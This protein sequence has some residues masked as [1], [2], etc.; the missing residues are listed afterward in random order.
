MAFIKLASTSDIKTGKM[1]RYSHAGERI[2]ICHVD[3]GFYAV[4]DNCSHEDFSLYLGALHGE[5]V[6]CSLHGGKFNVKTG[7]PVEEPACIALR[8][9]PLE[10]RDNDIY[11]DIDH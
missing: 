5:V 9:Y 3:D 6:K 8:T 11:V 7:A 4:S 10:V 2:L 1:E